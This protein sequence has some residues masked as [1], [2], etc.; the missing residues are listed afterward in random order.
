M[1]VLAASDDRRGEDV[2][3]RRLLVGAGG[4]A[5]ALAGCG[6][7]ASATR[8]NPEFRGADADVLDALLA[9]EN[10]A[11]AA[12]AHAAGLL[13]GSQ[14]ALAQRIGAQDAA[15]VYALAASIDRLGGTPSLAPASGAFA[16]GDA[17]AALRLAAVAEDMSIA[18]CLD[19]MPKITDPRARGLVVTIAANDAQHAVLIAQARGRSPFA[20]ALVRGKA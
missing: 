20:T 10:R 11:A 4:A 13:R 17:P 3:R 7:S 16:A 5:A 14:R 8:T 15:H 1:T 6:S 9:V 12:Y 19:A 18:A 2:S